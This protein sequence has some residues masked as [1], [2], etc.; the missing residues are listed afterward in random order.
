[1]NYDHIMIHYG[2][3]STKG[4]NKRAFIKELGKNIRHALKGY[5]SLEYHSDHDHTYITLN[6]EDPK[7]II[8]LLE[9]VAG[10]QRI[11]LVYKSEK[12][13][14]TLAKN[15]LGLIQN[16]EGKTFKVIAKR[17]DKTYPKHSFDIACDLGGYILKN[18]DLSVDVHKPDISLHV[19]IRAEAAYL[20]AHS[21]RGAGGYPLGMNGKVMMLLSGGIDSPVAAY[22]LLRRGIRIECIHFAAPPYTSDAVLDKLKDILA[23]LNIYQADIRLNIVPFTKLQLA[24]YQNVE[25]PYCITIMRRMMF[26][27]ADKLA[28]SHHCLGLATGESV[29]QVASQT[30]DS[31]IAINDVTNYPILRPLAVVDKLASIAMAEKIGTYEISVRPFEDCCTIFKPKRPKTKPK[32]SECEYYEKHFEWESLVDEAVKNVSVIIVKDGVSTFYEH[33]D[34]QEDN[35]ENKSEAE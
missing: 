31:M 13:F 7:P 29:G 11:S 8:S 10:I 12:D 28:K 32:I 4:N 22:L 27:I 30:L 17:I 24:I 34:M 9:E 20:Y 14:E 25:E 21:Y 15:A 35:E 33:D 3:L 19:E 26:R 6:G 16:E 1:M 18:T 5:S 2:E 23:K